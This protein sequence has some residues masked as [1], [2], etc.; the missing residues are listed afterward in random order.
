MSRIA[1]PATVEAAPE[2][3][4]PLLE[5]V[6]KMLGV[7]PNL[8]G[9]GVQQLCRAR[10]LRRNDRCACQGHVTRGHARAHRAGRR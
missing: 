2:A 6:G 9:P 10:R 7:V 3:S 5:A 4:R 1:T 8:F